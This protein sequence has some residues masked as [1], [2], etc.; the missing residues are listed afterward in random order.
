MDRQYY[1]D[2]Y[3]L[4]RNHWWFLARASILKKYI[5]KNIFDKKKLKILNVGVATG[6]S[7]EMLEAFGDVTSIEYEQECIDYIRHKVSIQVTQGSILDLKFESNSFDLVCAFDVIEH[8]K[9]DGLAASELMRV[10]AS[11]GS[12]LATVPAFMSLWSEH[13]L[14]NHHFKRYVKREIEVLFSDAKGGLVF[15]SYFNSILFFPIYLLRKLGGLIKRK[16]K[17]LSSDFTKFKP[18]FLNQT[19][20]H[21]MQLESIGL[22]RQISYPVGVSILCHWKKI[23]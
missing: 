17:K 4:E 9:E 23:K 21:I 16:G 1:K 15:V 19:L 2:Y 10:C 11:G 22:S 13:D 7:T 14:I 18:G 8:V 5:G 20:N 3:F 12:V 6:A